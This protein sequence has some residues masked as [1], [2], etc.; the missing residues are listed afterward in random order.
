MGNIIFT[1][2]EVDIIV[3]TDNDPKGNIDSMT[4]ILSLP[5]IDIK[6]EQVNSLKNNIS[7]LKH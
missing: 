3:Q 1:T 5:V 6:P 4:S 2:P 7:M